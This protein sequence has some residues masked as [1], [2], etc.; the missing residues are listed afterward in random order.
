MDTWRRGTGKTVLSCKV[1]IEKHILFGV[2]TV[3]QFLGRGKVKI[4]TQA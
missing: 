4:Q 1:G 3:C 2:V